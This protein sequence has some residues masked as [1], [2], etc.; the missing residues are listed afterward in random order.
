M[1]IEDSILNALKTTEVQALRSQFAKIS[2]GTIFSFRSIKTMLAQMQQ[3]QVAG[4]VRRRPLIA[5]KV[6][7]D[8]VIVFFFFLLSSIYAI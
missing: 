3:L 5:A 4:G 2:A 7:S 1:A 8:N 6:F